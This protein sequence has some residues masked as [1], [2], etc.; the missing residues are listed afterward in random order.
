[1]FWAINFK[2]H[3][4]VYHRVNLI[5]YLPSCFFSNL[6]ENTRAPWISTR[7]P[8]HKCILRCFVLSDLQLPTA[9]AVKAG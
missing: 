8:Q 1:M 5:K 6:I 7:L 4:K 2:R 3:I 9:L